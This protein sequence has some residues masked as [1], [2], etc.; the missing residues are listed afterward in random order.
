MT[1]RCLPYYDFQ[2]QPYWIDKST[3]LEHFDQHDF[4]ER[5]DVM[6]VEPYYRQDWFETSADGHLQFILPAVFLIDSKSQFI[7]GR[8]RTA[9]LFANN[10]KKIPI[11]FDV[12]KPN[13]KAFVKRLQL[14]R[15][16]DDEILRLPALP[17][18]E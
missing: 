7:N 14:Q 11:A 6:D 18:N 9:V 4:I 2:D 12:S 17:I 3:F 1:L 10:V 5:R 8:H 13:T 16:R 15:I